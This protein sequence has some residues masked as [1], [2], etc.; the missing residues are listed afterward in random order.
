MTIK[1]KGVI[2]SAITIIGLFLIVT[3]AYTSLNKIKDGYTK[4]HEIS[5]E[6][7]YLKSVMIGGLLFNSSSAVV[8]MNPNSTKAKKSMSSGIKKIE[9]FFKKIKK[10]NPKAVSSIENEYSSFIKISEK[11]LTKVQNKGK[12]TKSDLNDRLK[13]WRNLKFKTIELL[14]NIKPRSTKMNNKYEELINTTTTNLVLAIG[15]LGLVIVIMTTFILK[16]IINAIDNMQKR[17]QK[18]L[19]SNSLEE[20][21]T[22]HGNDELSKI[23]NTINKLLD[24]AM[25]ATQEAFSKTE[26]AQKALKDVQQASKY[27]NMVVKLNDMLTTN[28]IDNIKNTQNG[29][30]ANIDDL[31]HIN[32][33]NEQTKD[34]VNNLNGYTNKVIK[35]MEN[36]LEVVHS[37]NEHSEHLNRSVDE[38]S[39]VISLIKDISD[40]TNLLALNA[41]I[42]AA[43]A[44]EHGRGFAVVA[45]EVRKLAEKTQKATNEVEVN[46]NLLKQNTISIVE[47]GTNLQNVSHNSL[48]VLSQFKSK[49]SSIIDMSKTL[50][51]ENRQI[52]NKIFINLAKLDHINFKAEGYHSIIENR[53]PQNMLSH[54]ECNF[55]KWYE[56]DGK[57]EFGSNEKYTQID[58][59][60]EVVHSSIKHALSYIKTDS[61]LENVE[62]IIN[63]F[64]A[65]E[66]ST[67]E[68]FSI[69]DEI[70]TE[71]KE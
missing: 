23:E 43:R 63:N 3:Y 52:T 44:G 4:S 13:A 51:V 8:F 21:I 15:I 69:V 5:L 35:N 56:N 19:D 67:K 33:L 6:E 20:R 48:D 61:V 39:N 1:Q 49:F 40:Q 42:E 25:L 30:K 47:D 41:A 9:T 62:D 14:K 18:I 68:L 71:K 22:I 38:I 2:F 11:L 32:T 64:E 55:G 65:T 24:R 12:L 28:V 37:S 70:V 10:L 66:Q 16:V 34:M 53:Y 57:K 7:S 31:Q 54:K 59:P 27:T 36:I 17:V 50:R 45:D 46:I 60:H 29:L 58:R 26:V